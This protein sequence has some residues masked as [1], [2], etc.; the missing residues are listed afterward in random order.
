ML[1]IVNVIH[2]PH[3]R[4][5][6]LGGGPEPSHGHPFRG[7]HWTLDLQCDLIIK[8]KTEGIHSAIEI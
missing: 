4:K 8:N 6:L 2:F 5:Y 3:Q 7:R 1:Y